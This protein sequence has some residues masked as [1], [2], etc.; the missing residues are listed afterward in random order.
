M[1]CGYFR[2]F[3]LQVHYLG[4]KFSLK[5]TVLSLSNFHDIGLL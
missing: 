5:E 2:L 4:F 1:E 3:R